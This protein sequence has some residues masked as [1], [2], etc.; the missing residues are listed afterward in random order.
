M[1]IYLS[2]TYAIQ[3]IPPSNAI[4]ECLT[5]L[6][7]FHGI[8]SYISRIKMSRYNRMC[9]CGCVPVCVAVCVS[10]CKVGLPISD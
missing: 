6:N 7:Y 3:L 5:A 2:S 1:G 8:V 9:V 10:L 4:P